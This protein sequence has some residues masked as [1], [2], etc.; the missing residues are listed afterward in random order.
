MPCAQDFPVEAGAFAGDDVPGL[1]TAFP[2]LLR[3]FD[4][5]IEDLPAKGQ[6]IRLRQ[7]SSWVKN[8]QLQGLFVQS[9][10]WAPAEPN[11]AWL[12]ASK[13]RDERRQVSLWA[14]EQVG[15]TT[16]GA[17]NGA[18]NVQGQGVGVYEMPRQVP[19]GVTRT[20]HENQPLR[21]IREILM[22]PAPNRHRCL[23]RIIQHYPKDTHDLCAER[24]DEGA[25]KPKRR[26]GVNEPKAASKGKNDQLDKK[27][28]WNLSFLIEDATGKMTVNV[29]PEDGREF[30]PHIEP[31]D[32]WDNESAFVKVEKTMRALTVKEDR[33]PGEG[34]VQMCVMS[35]VGEDGRRFHRLFG[36][37]VL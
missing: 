33:A 3:Q 21:S 15:A 24:D 26:K 18:N 25:T 34:W 10:K 19:F 6:W 17:N 2:V 16:N 31:C 12:T 14:N 11:H 5:E 1:G 9:S 27:W 30:F 8:G 22:A 36:T 23:V 32:L 13:T 37:R 4:I 7:L 20:M 28:E 35:Y 29:A